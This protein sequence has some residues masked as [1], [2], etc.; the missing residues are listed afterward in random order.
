MRS[1]PSLRRFS[2]VAFETVPVFCLSDDGPLSSSQGRSSSA[3]SFHASLSQAIDGVISLALFPQVVSQA[4]QHFKSS[5]KQATG[6][7]CFARQSICSIIS[8]H[9]GMSSLVHPQ[10][11]SKVDADH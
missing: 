7:G 1:T 8:L 4:P 10:E 11:F 2:N 6:E 3:F 9:S 5:E